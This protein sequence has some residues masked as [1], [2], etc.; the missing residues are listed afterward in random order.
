MIA[1]GLGG[2]LVVVIAGSALIGGRSSGEIPV[3]HADQR[4]IR[5]K[6]ENPGG[7]QRAGLDNEIFS[8]AENGTAKLAP[9][10]EMPDPKALRAAPPPAPASLAA[11]PAAPPAIHA[12]KPEPAPA[13]PAAATA[14]LP[15]AKPAIV[16]AALTA[17]RPAPV[18]APPAAKPAPVMAA[19]APA[20][21]EKPMPVAPA[22][23]VHQ[24]PAG[25][26]TAVQ[27][28]A[29]SSEAAARSEWQSLTRRM[30]DLLGGRQPAFSRT[31]RDGRT[32]WRIRTSGFTDVNEAKSFCARVRAKGGGC[33]VAEF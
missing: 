31:E 9:P 2:L 29:V 5:V 25:R 16:P 33:T 8:G 18:V 14:G 23:A 17:A 30:P 15:A 12:V 21:I 1:G 10:A 22:P 19:P 7:L 28:A 11:I 26:S 27:L 24:V 4:P 32:F 3:V 20:M 6:P 13:R